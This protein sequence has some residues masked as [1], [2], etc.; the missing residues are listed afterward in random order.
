MKTLIAGVVLLVSAVQV[1]ASCKEFLEEVKPYQINYAVATTIFQQQAAL[2]GMLLVQ[3]QHSGEACKFDPSA[4]AGQVAKERARVRRN[5]EEAA[6]REEE[7]KIKADVQSI[8]MEHKKA[9]KEYNLCVKT[10][11]GD[12]LSWCTEI[13]TKGSSIEYLKSQSLA[14]KQRSE[15]AETVRIAA[16]RQVESEIKRRQEFDLC[17]TSTNFELINR[18]REL[19]RN[20]ELTLETLKANVEG[21]LR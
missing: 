4:Y 20:K 7:E 21:S 19:L 16:A 5:E 9:T 15:Q 8:I 10:Q 17:L 13:M 11:T 18:C 1:Q 14:R 6:R 12:V 3:N 2:T